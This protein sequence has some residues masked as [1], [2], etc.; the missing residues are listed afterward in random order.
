MKRIE[1]NVRRWLGTEC[2]TYAMRNTL[3]QCLAS[4]SMLPYFGARA[5]NRTTKG[6]TV[7]PEA[8]LCFIWVLNF[9]SKTYRRLM[10]GS[11]FCDF[12]TDEVALQ[13]LINYGV[14]IPS[15]N[16]TL[17]SLRNGS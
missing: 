10:W 2:V 16:V 11:V 14:I 12:R 7:R 15:I 5:G 8:I 17:N 4:S 6:L 13:S 9:R 3:C 1:A